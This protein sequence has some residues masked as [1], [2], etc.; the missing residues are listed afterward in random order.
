MSSP[1]RMM[2][3]SYAIL[4]ARACRRHADLRSII[5]ILL[6]ILGVCGCRHS[7]VQPTIRPAV[8]HLS[9]R[10]VSSDVGVQFTLGH[11]GR[12]PLD[13]LETIGHGC[14]WIDYDQD[15]R[16]DLLLLGPDRVSL[17]HNDGAG[18]REVSERQGIAQAG[19]W[20][21]VAV[22]DYDNDGWPDLFLSGHHC[23]ALLHNERGAGFRD[24]TTQHGIPPE[25]G[26]GTSAIFVDLNQDGFLDICQGHYV[27]FGAES[28]RYCVEA[29]TKITC[30]PHIYP[31]ERITLFRSEK[32]RVFH[33]LTSASGLDHTAGRSLGL[34]P[35]DYDDDGRTDLFVANDTEPADMFR[36]SPS[37]KLENVAH[38]SGVALAPDGAALGGMGVDAQDYDRDGRLDLLV[39]TFEAEPK[40]LWHGESG[41]RFEDRSG[42]VGLDILRPLVSWGVGLVD[43]DNDGWLDLL[44]ASGH[45]AVGRKDPNHHYAQ[46]LYLLRGTGTEFRDETAS[47]DKSLR[48]PIVGRGSA[49]GDYDN[50]GRI[51]AV[52]SNLE[53]GVLLLHNESPRSGHWLTLKLI[54]SDSNRMGLGARVTVVAGSQRWVAEARTARSIFSASD[55]RLHFGLGTAG[56]VDRILV[57]WPSGKTSSVSAQ[58]VDRQLVMREP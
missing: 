17:Y 29:D 54:G 40:C 50:D 30:A 56:Q 49:F 51:D 20:I 12:S 55:A 2:L 46:P 5:C 18:F 52:I 9:L 53:G 34:M 31:A 27:S 35:M 11:R 14:A 42:Q 25:K 19:Y 6:A 28:Q 1:H 16:L 57:R 47:L 44:C 32:G 24:V 7:S 3:R 33:D 58:S 23:R 43:L 13:I 36:N 37:G 15:N 48:E 41:G 38:L 26:W 10:N 45:V 4:R 22:G 39:S 21:G 8:P